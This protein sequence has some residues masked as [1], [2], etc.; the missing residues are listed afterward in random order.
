MSKDLATLGTQSFNNPKYTITSHKL[1]DM[2]GTWKTYLP[3]IG[4]DA[5]YINELKVFDKKGTDVMVLF[6]KNNDTL[7]YFVEGVYYEVKRVS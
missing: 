6:I 4:I 2:G 3:N 1:D 7:L 5:N